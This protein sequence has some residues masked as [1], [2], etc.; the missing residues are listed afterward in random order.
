MTLLT[1]DAWWHSAPMVGGLWVAIGILASTVGYFF[2]S[3]QADRKLIA[4]L[5]GEINEVKVMLKGLDNG[6]SIAVV[7]SRVN[8][9]HEWYMG[10]IKGRKR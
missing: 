3:W 6:T 7:V 4:D 10:Q 9:I 5:K 8:D 1:E 2:R